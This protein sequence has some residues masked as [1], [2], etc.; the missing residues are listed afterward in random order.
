M[1]CPRHLQ[2]SVACHA[3]YSTCAGTP[4]RN[5]LCRVTR[6]RRLTHPSW[7]RI[8]AWRSR[9][10]PSSR[11][12]P[13]CICATTSTRSSATTRRQH[14][15]SVLCR[16]SSVPCANPWTRQITTM[17]TTSPCSATASRSSTTRPPVWSWRRVCV[18]CDARIRRSISYPSASSFRARNSFAM[19][20]A[21]RPARLSPVPA[22]WPAP[23]WADS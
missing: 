11:S 17:W 2:L 16:S 3:A 8:R 4:T 13:S 23:S 20:R 9:R 7:H 1:F 15:G 5:S 22:R 14:S 10:T 21:S 6:A 19:W 12:V 18:C